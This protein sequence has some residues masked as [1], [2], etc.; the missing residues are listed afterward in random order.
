MEQSAPVDASAQ[1]ENCRRPLERMDPQ[2]TSIQPGGGV[3]V[4]L[5]MAWGRWRRFWLTTFRPKYVS[6]MRSLRKGEHAGCP[7][8][9]IDP[10]DIKYY[11]N[12]GGYFWE[13]DDDAFTWR[14]RLPFARTGLAELLVLTAL[15][16][17]GSAGIVTIAR[18]AD[19]T[20]LPAVVASVVS[21]ALF[22]CGL[23]IVWF[24][25]DPPRRIPQEKGLVVA[26]ADG[27]IVAIE[28]L[29]YDSDID[30]PAI[31]IGIFLSIFN[32]H[33]NRMPMAARVI[34]LSYRR[35]KF[36]N[37]L[38][39]ESARENEQ[40]AV[41][42]EQ[43]E[44][45]YRPMVVRQITGAIARRIV[46]WLKPGDELTVGEQFGMIKLGSRTELIIPREHG[47]QMLTKIGESVTAG[48][49]VLAR[50]ECDSDSDSK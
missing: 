40:L 14:D 34:G 29:E 12:Q 15:F 38:R 47:L 13:P 30:G 36:L 37:A 44:A 11:Q 32:V 28:E 7:F 41:R 20:G 48:V 9:P 50:Y 27:K 42:A 49:S 23:L 24:F 10:R 18:V 25:R 22:V 45:P 33:I 21:L 19:W 6:R 16:F 8:E 3:I 1:S 39:P 31:L 2:L 17:G 43:L 35:G 4:K 26:P 46:C 5:E